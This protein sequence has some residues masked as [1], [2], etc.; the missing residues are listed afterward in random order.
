M[1]KMK[2][3]S[4]RVVILVL[5]FTTTEVMNREQIELLNHSECC[6]FNDSSI[7]KKV[8]GTL[9]DIVNDTGDWLV[10]TDGTTLFMCP[11]NGSHCEDDDY[12][13]DI[14]LYAIQTFIYCI[15]FVFASC[16]IA[17]HLYFKDLRTVFGV[18]IT[19]FCFFLDVNQIIKLI[20]NRYQFTHKMDESAVCATFV[21]LR[22]IVNF[23]DHSIKFT[24][25]FHFTYLMYNS[26]R[27]KSGGPRLD[28]V[29]L[30]KYA[31][32]ICSLTTIYTLVVIPYDLA[33]ARDAFKTEGGYCAISFVDGTAVIIFIAQLAF[34]TVVELTTFCVGMIFYFLVS[35]HCCEFK[36][37]DIRVSFVLVATA[38]LN[39]LSFLVCYVLSDSTSYAFLASSVATTLEQTIL[40]AIFLTSKKVKSVFISTQ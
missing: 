35:K 34:L 6:I 40:F 38:G 10:S 39:R 17:L 13:P 7:I 25:L 8:D 5:L 16:T 11:T 30:C 4:F 9:L 22:G 14:V 23:L 12:K 29:L 21:Y 20:H 27:A 28:K 24:V 18:L 1:C 19:M 36:T 33:V 37:S 31:V 32:F 3:Y 26:Y 15:N 2:W